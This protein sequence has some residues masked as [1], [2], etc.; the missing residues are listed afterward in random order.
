VLGLVSKPHVLELLQVV[1][2]FSLNALHEYWLCDLYLKAMVCL[3]KTI[4]DSNG[5]IFPDE[6]DNDSENV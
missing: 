5:N 4:S 1:N 6:T 3:R 2:I